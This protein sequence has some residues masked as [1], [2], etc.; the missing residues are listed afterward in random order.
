MPKLLQQSWD[1]DPVLVL[2]H[3]KAHKQL[4]ELVLN[5]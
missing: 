1:I 5:M 3:V 2:F 4:R